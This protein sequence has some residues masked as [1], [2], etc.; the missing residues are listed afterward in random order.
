[1]H[2]QPSARAVGWISRALGITALLGLADPGPGHARPDPVEACTGGAAEA[3]LSGEWLAAETML[4]QRLDD[5]HCRP[6][7]ADVALSLAFVIEQRH[8]RGQAVS[9]CEAFSFYRRASEW[10]PVA[11]VRAAAEAGMSRLAAPCAAQR[12]DPP[13]ARGGGSPDFARSKGPSAAPTRGWV[14][15]MGLT[16]AASGAAG[17]TALSVAATHARDR[18]DAARQAEAIAALDAEAG[19]L[20]DRTAQTAR[21]RAREASI[22]GWALVGISAAAALATAWLADGAPSND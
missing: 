11:A 7:R 6:V 14:W 20:A 21:R 10:A 22:A 19:H 13:R 17:I 5:D 18:R 9:V 3:Q 2:A 1:M 16:A 4:R 8:G 15:A 12:L